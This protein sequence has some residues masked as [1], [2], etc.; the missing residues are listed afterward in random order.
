MDMLSAL[1]VSLVPDMHQDGA[2]SLTDLPLHVLEMI[3]MDAV[4]E[5]APRGLIAPAVRVS[6]KLMRDVFD[7]TN[8]RL[9]AHVQPWKGGVDEDETCAAELDAPNPYHAAPLALYAVLSL[10][11]KSRLLQSL[12]LNDVGLGDERA[13]ELCSALTSRPPNLLNHLDLSGNGLGPRAGA[14]LAGLIRDSRSLTRLNLGRNSLWLGG[15]W[16]LAEALASPHPAP[17]CHL[18]LA[19]NVIGA[20]GCAALAQAL[21]AAGSGLRH[22]V[23]NNNDLRDAGAVALAHVLETNTTLQHLELDNNAIGKAGVAALGKALQIN[24]EASGLQHLSLQCNPIGSGVISLAAA[25]TCNTSLARLQLCY[26][27]LGAEEGTALCAALGSNRSLRHLD[28]TA[29]AISQEGILPLPEALR[30]NTT[31]THLNLERNSVGAICSDPE[32]HTVYNIHSNMPAVSRPF[33]ASQHAVCMVLVC[34]CKTGV[35]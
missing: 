21:G 15:V 19:D 9:A 22:L 26:C 3:V 5:A 16:A 6:C 24:T 18:D 12:L 31:L 29:N 27:G 32:R 34:S 2:S 35:Q 20:T 10:V 33:D 8:S 23:L 4:G 30:V 1:S 7:G 17:L 25:L 11:D 28:L 13:E 14:A